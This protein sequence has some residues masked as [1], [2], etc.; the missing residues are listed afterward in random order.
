MIAIGCDHA[1]VE[2]KK[3]IIEA[4]S[5]QGFDFLDMA[6]TENLAII[7]ML[8]KRSATKFYQVIVPEVYSF[9]VQ[10]SVCQLPQT[11]SRESERL[12]AAIHSPHALQDFTMT[13]MSC[14]WVQEL[15]AADLRLSLQKYSSLLHLRA[16]VTRDGLT[17]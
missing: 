10:V 13:L 8:Q 9:A 7:L 2:M 6:R 15:L 1:G 14:V 17:S 4:L 16:D 5:I 12:C 3:A 11:R